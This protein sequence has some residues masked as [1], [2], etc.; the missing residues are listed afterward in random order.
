MFNNKIY[1]QISFDIPMRSPLS[2]IIAELRDLEEKVLNSIN[3]NS[4]IYRY[5][6]HIIMSVPS[7]RVDDIL[8]TFNSFHDRLQ[9]TIWNWN[10]KK[11]T[12]NFL[13]RSLKIN[14]DEIIIDWFHKET[15]SFIATFLFTLTYSY[16]TQD[17]C[18]FQLIEVFFSH[19]QYIAKKI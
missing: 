10:W 15:F 4:I 9:F 14:N 7:N 5:V 13:D 6:D 2:P 3:L 8:I 11:K 19:T 18:Y 12:L 17:R 1:Q 16:L